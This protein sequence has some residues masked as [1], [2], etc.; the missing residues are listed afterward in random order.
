MELEAPTPRER[1]ETMQ[2]CKEEGFFVKIN[3]IPMLPF[4]SDSE[5]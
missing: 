1:L 4:M 3:F 2:K 5:E